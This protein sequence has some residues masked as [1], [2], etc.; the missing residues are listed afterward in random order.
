MK[1]YRKKIGFSQEQLADK[2]Q[3]DRTYISLLERG[4][5]VPTITTLFKLAEALNIMP[6]EIVRKIEEEL[7]DLCDR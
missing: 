3:L 4:E 5:R 7:K 6:S 2:S 1:F